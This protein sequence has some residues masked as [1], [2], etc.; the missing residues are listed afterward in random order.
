M[1]HVGGSEIDCWEAKGRRGI[2]SWN[3]MAVLVERC[4]GR[5]IGGAVGGESG[6]QKPEAPS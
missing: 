5:N 4:L 2:S 3:K 1:K 6:E